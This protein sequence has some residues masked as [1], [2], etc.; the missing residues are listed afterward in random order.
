[1][2]LN[3]LKKYRNILILGYGIEGRA[4]EAFLKRHCPECKIGVAD[5]NS[6]VNY[7]ELQ[8]NYDLVVKAPGIPK[9]LITRPYTTATNIFFAQCLGKTIGV[10]G[11]KGKSTVSSLVHHILIN[12]G[13]SSHL[14]GNIGRPMLSELENGKG[15]DD[16][17]VVELSSYQLSDIRYSPHISVITNLFPDH[18][19]YHGS[20]EEYYRA[21]LN[22][23]SH[24]T[25]SNFFVYNPAYDTLLKAAQSSA[26]KPV[27]I[28]LD[29]PLSVSDSPLLGD[30]NMVNIKAA[31]TVSELCGVSV[32][33]AVRAL[34]SF[35]PLQHR[36][37]YVGEFDGIA[38]YDD[39]ASTTPQSTVSAV[40]TLKS[41]DT[42]FLGGEDRGYDFSELAKVI[43][44]SSVN[45]IVLFPDAG[46][47]IKQSI[48]ANC[49]REILFF[50]TESMEQAV[51]FAASKTKKGMICLL[52]TAC[53]SYSLW[54]NFVEKG[55]EFA[56]CVLN[57]K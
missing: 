45:N 47:T 21:K 4:T 2:K 39:A 17:Y 46:K 13:L 51:A 27:K 43:C 37:E 11:T 41:V 1:M 14:V 38:Y 48:M 5:R 8:D 26:A 32:D 9:N 56:R 6:N 28:M 16:I 34:K 50:D 3:D 12:E 22:I 57:H 33:S 10:T 31:V 53:P 7:L 19:T 55:E 29:L 25:P 15:K 23:L 42:I 20:V 40:K 36:L 30:H 54:K 49:D 24:A 52:S 18:M 35:R 44:A